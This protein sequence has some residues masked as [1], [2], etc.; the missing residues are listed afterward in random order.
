MTITDKLDHVAAVEHIA[1]ARS[2][3]FATLDL[4]GDLRVWS[5]SGVLIR[6]EHL[7]L[8]EEVTQLVVSQQAT[9]FAT[10][11]TSGTCTLSEFSRRAP[12]RHVSNAW[13]AAFASD[14]A[15]SVAVGNGP[16]AVEVGDLRGNLKWREELR[17]EFIVGI[18]FA[19]K[20][21]IAHGPM[22][23]E[24]RDRDTGAYVAELKKPEISA[25]LFAASAFSGDVALITRGPRLV[26]VDSSLRAA[27]ID[28][29][30]ALAGL[31]ISDDGQTIFLAF[32]DGG[33][34]TV[35]RGSLSAGPELHFRPTRVC[36]RFVAEDMVAIAADARVHIVKLTGR[37]GSQV[38]DRKEP[39]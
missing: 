15:F 22:G 20:Y 23:I 32:A 7:A 39:G 24:W 25:N 38:R 37:D 1:M 35:A 28:L 5:T 17:L 13:A 27:S 3:V 36:S 4:A 26:C 14:D 31:A 19:G 9:Y 12:L 29:R 2:G 34:M 16:I 18:C 10:T 30:G 8:E 6:A 33:T 11:T 21:L